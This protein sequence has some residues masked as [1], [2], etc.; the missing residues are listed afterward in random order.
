MK[1]PLPERIKVHLDRGYDSA[2]TRQEL[3]ERGLEAQIAQHGLPAPVQ[4]G[5]R[6][7]VERTHAWVLRATVCNA[8]MSVAGSDRCVLFACPC[9]HHA[10]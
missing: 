4:A 5:M 7:P 3:A 2:K 10:A 8:A 1:G 6:W 9:D